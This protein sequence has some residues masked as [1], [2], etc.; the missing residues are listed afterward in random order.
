MARFL[1]QVVLVLLCV[2]WGSLDSATPVE[3]VSPNGNI[4]IAFWLS[5]LGQALYSISYQGEKL[6][7][8]SPLGLV[9][10]QGG[11]WGD[12]LMIKRVSHQSIYESYDLIVGKSRTAHNHCNEMT[13]QLLESKS[14]KRRID[15]IFRAYDDGAAFRYS[16]PRQGALRN[17]EIVAEKSQFRFPENFKCWALRLGKFTSNYEKEFEPIPV[18]E[19]APDALVGLPLTIEIENGPALAITEANLKN[20]AGMYLNGLPDVA[21]ALM[22]VLSPLPEGGGVCVKTITPHV[23]PWRVIMIGDSPGD[24]IESNLILN[25]NEPLAIQ[26]P[27]WIKPGRVAWDWWSGQLVDDPK[28]ASGMNN[29]TMK[30]Y[31]D[32]AAENGLEYMLIDAGWYGFHRNKEADITQMIP[33]I[34][35]PGLVEYARAKDVAILIWLNWESV[36]RQ[37]DVAFALYEKWGVAGVKIDYMDRDDQ[38][39]VDFYWKTVK[40]AAEH[41]LIVD[42]HGAYKPTGMRRTFPNLMTREGIL[43]LE[44]LKWSNRATPEHNVTIPFTRMLA[45][46][47]DYT[48]GGFNNV[49]P[50]EFKSQRINPMVPTTRCHQLAMFVVYE[51]PLQMLSDSPANY[52]NQLGLD[53]LRIV[54]TSWDETHVVAGKIGDFVAIARKSGEKWFL[55]AMTDGDPRSLEVPLDF[56]GTGEFKTI[57][58][59]DG[60]GAERVPTRLMKSETIVSP[61]DKLSAKMANGG[62]LAAVFE[63]IK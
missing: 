2:F 59:S 52:R 35:I 32:F 47:M 54:P 51:S 12:G 25:L 27:S 49:T 23:T 6:L 33:E 1:T 15:M 53:F 30:H 46:P 41:R 3:V 45:G 58:W 10:N 28:I 37:M 13:V 17:M 31:I 8:E 63:P 11:S 42:F 22:S 34:D 38:E 24:L 4:R 57:I 26:D 18:A 16:F 29:E 21:N 39:V 9:L 14:P 56:L 55:G 19:I 62:G 20:Y 44:Y 50:I 7:S 60:P 40:K 5:D 43:G 48:P 36:K 61:Q